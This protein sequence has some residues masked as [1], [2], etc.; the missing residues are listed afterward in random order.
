[1]KVR[2]GRGIGG[3]RGKGLPVQTPSL[4]PD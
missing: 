1:L 3:V 4:T 2:P